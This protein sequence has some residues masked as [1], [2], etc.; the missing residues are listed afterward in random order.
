MTAGPE[1][2]VVEATGLGKSYR[3]SWRGP[4]VGALR[5]VSLALRA[6]EMA[7]LAGPN[8]AGKSTLLRLLAG[9]A[10]P[11]A[12][13]VTYAGGGARIGY[14]P[15][16]LHWP[17]QLTCLELLRALGG[18]QEPAAT[19]SECLDSL[20][21]TKLEALAAARVGAL[22]H[23]QRQRLALAQAL[24]ARPKLLLLDEPFNGLDPRTARDFGAVLERLSREGAA[25]VVSTHVF[26]PVAGVCRRLLVLDRGE[27]V[28]DARSGPGFAAGEIEQAY[29]SRTEARV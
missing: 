29:F 24:L 15:E 7:V 27:L 11:D 9:L 21:A 18:L 19:K 5:G 22:S 3:G 26:G 10:W 25:V 28:H 20:R 8:G 14:V 12:G 23:G 6:G 1:Q 16:A 2:V 4:T 17:A 13:R